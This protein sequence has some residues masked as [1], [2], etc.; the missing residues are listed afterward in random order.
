MVLD[1][2]RCSS[3]PHQ[4]PA[5]D[6]FYPCLL[7]PELSA[8]HHCRRKASRL[9]IRGWLAHKGMSSNQQSIGGVVLGVPSVSGKPEENSLELALGSYN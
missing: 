7:F 6:T 9:A 8:A 4:L 2:L 1:D 3:L 5:A